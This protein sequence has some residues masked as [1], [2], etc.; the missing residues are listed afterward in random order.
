MASNSY[1]PNYNFQSNGV[2]PAKLDQQF[3]AIKNALDGIVSALNVIT[4]TDG[5]LGNSTVTPRSLTDELVRFIMGNVNN[6]RLRGPWASGVRYAFGDI[7][8]QGGKAYGASVAHDSSTDFAVDKSLGYWQFLSNDSEAYALTSYVDSQITQLLAQLADPVDGYETIAHA[9]AT[10]APK[11]SPQ[12]SGL[13]LAPVLDVSQAQAHAAA[14]AT[15]G[16]V[17]SILASKNTWNKAQAVQQK[18]L[19]CTSSIVTDCG[20]SNVFLLT[21]TSNATLENPIN[22]VAGGTYIWNIY[23]DSIGGK[24]LSYGSLFRFP[25]RSTPSL[26]SSAGAGDTLTAVYDGKI[27]RAAMARNY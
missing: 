3:S 2:D 22:L 27:L 5:K 18:E 19:E 1:N 21:L 14:I 11:N 25:S 10:Y 26:T 13:P 6:W 7:V 15:L 24:L 23:Q 9:E 8:E 4:R 17:I 16:S 12:F 20:E